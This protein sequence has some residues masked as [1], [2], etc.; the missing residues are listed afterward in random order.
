MII[1]WLK[2]KIRQVVK[3]ISRLKFSEVLL[4]ILPN[5]RINKIPNNES[6]LGRII[7]LF[8][9]IFARYSDPKSVIYRNVKFR[10]KDD[11]SMKLDVNEFT[12][13]G[14]YF[15][16][17]DKELIQ[18][19][20]LGGGV[21]LDIGANVGIFSLIA[22]QTFGK[23]YCFEPNHKTFKLLE[24]NIHLNEVHN[25]TAYNI[26]LSDQNSVMKLYHNPLNNGGASLTK[27]CREL[28]RE[29]DN[30]SWDET[31]VSVKTLDLVIGESVKSVDLIKIDV[32]GHELP[33]LK[34]ALGI[35][36][37]SRPLIFAEVACDYDKILNILLSLPKSYYAYSL[38]DKKKIDVQVMVVVPNDILFI[39]EEKTSVIE[40]L[41]L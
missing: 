40:K 19:I 36:K 1:K 33:A 11:F 22:S 10:F 32:E 4:R 29:G 35:I 23:V 39:P 27:F 31:E 17:P 12:Q 28:N 30:F 15:G 21:F 38:I 24:A 20:Q 37:A 7:R 41:C 14:Y 6:D 3:L 2:K 8:F 34:G 18:L 9:T 25:I 26:G 13:C 5:N 16:A